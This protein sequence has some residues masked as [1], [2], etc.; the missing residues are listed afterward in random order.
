MIYFGLV[1]T[2][3]SELRVVER[4]KVG[5]HYVD[6]VTVADNFY[7]NLQRLN[8]HYAMFDTIQVVDTSA[9]SGPKV[10]AVFVNSEVEAS[11]AFADLPEWFVVNL[12][13]LA[14]KIKQ[15]S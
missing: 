10:L 2:N 12:P 1:N 11:V 9:G 7:G 4:T 3:F 15:S 6:P 5:G 13:S 8:K 14:E